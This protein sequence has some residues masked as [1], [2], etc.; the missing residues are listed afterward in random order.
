MSFKKRRSMAFKLLKRDYIVLLLALHS[1]M[2]PFMVYLV[3]SVVQGVGILNGPLFFIFTKNHLLLFLLAFITS[4]LVYQGRKAALLFLVFHN[5]LS[6][7][8]MFSFYYTNNSKVAFFYASLNVIVS[9]MF[10]SLWIDENATAI[11]RPRYSAKRL[12]KIGV[13]KLQVKLIPEWGEEIK[14][15]LT[16]WSKGSFFMILEQNNL[17]AHPEKVKF[18]VTFEGK[19]FFGC[20][21]IVST[22]S[23]GLG[24]QVAKELNDTLPFHWKDLYTIIID[25]GF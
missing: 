4:Y 1:A 13:D 9:I 5:L 23:R 20:G 17:D 25:R 8:Y 21:E 15:K 16:S 18:E 6:L 24:V 10:I 19:T 12:G 22:Y 3:D 7:I 14:G 11:Y 2:L